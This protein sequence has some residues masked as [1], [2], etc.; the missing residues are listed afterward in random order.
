MSSPLAKTSNTEPA[1]SLAAR[2][3]ASDNSSPQGGAPNGG[4]NPVR[5]IK[6]METESNPLPGLVPQPSKRRKSITDL[7]PMKE[8]RT[9]I[10]GKFLR[11]VSMNVVDL[12]AD[13]QLTVGDDPKNSNVVHPDDGPLLPV[14]NSHPDNT[15]G[16][17]P[18]PPTTTI[19]TPPPNANFSSNETIEEN[20]PP[21]IDEAPNVLNHNDD[22]ESTPP[23]VNNETGSANS[24]PSALKRAGYSV[25]VSLSYYQFKV[26]I[27]SILTSIPSVL[28]MWGTVYLIDHLHDNEGQDGHIIACAI[29]MTCLD[30]FIACAFKFNRAFMKR[31]VIHWP[32]Q[33]LIYC[34]VMYLLDWKGGNWTSV[35]M[36]TSYGL[37]SGCSFPVA[38]DP[39]KTFKKIPKCFKFK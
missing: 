10:V 37:G 16:A 9:S 39:P 23:P 4:P 3:E 17:I 36:S 5:V 13:F 18:S 33:I 7:T 2:E 6:D 14:T 19:I 34:F 11:R 27:E 30:L 35:I 26:T 31:K 32:M 28:L 25:Q 20:K 22:I 38:P 29:C 12:G 8:H 15:A 1:V 24:S 21:A